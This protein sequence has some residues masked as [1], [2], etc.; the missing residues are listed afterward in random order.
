MNLQQDFLT[1][2]I[3][4]ATRAGRVGILVD[5]GSTKARIAWP[6]MVADGAGGKVPHPT[7]TRRTWIPFKEI[8]SIK[9]PPRVV[10]NLKIKTNAK[11]N[12]LSTV[13][14]AV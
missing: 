10:R 7:R 8:K 11:K 14:N 1:A 5:I 12:E 4:I 2:G 3:E 13:K 6:V 9:W